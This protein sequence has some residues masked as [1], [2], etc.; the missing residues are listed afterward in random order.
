MVETGNKTV[1]F[2]EW[3]EKYLAEFAVNIG[4]KEITIHT[5]EFEKLY[6]AWKAGYAQ[7]KKELEIT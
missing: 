1:Q 2:H 5:G 4:E 3:L 7:G 6:N